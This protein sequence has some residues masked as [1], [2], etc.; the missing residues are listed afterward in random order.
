MGS[1]IPPTGAT[2]LSATPARGGRID[3]IDT[4]TFK[5]ADTLDAGNFIGALAVDPLA[6][7]FVV[8]V[9]HRLL[10]WSIR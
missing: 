4:H 2:S 3:F 8:T 1:P 5:V 6:P 9:G 10:I 7:M